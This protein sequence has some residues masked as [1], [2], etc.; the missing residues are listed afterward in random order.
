MV[1]TRS[2]ATGVRASTT[3][4]EGTTLAHYPI[5]R[6]ILRCVGLA[7]NR[8]LVI[9]KGLPNGHTPLLSGSVVGA[10]GG[11]TSLHPYRHRC[12]N[13][14]D[15]ESIRVDCAASTLAALGLKEAEMRLIGCD[16]HASQQ[17]LRCWIATQ[18][19]ANTRSLLYAW[20]S[21]SQKL[22]ID[23]TCRRAPFVRCPIW[24]SLRLRPPQR[25]RQRCHPQ[26]GC[27]DVDPLRQTQPWRGSRHGSSQ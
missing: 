7:V 3:I 4:G 23:T 24:G 16:L 25:R 6:G 1:S 20:P 17:W 26:H 21:G 10:L 8:G 9:A 15:L 14:V 27:V 5:L 18:T 19:T 2:V 22:G 12:H 11:R 13:D